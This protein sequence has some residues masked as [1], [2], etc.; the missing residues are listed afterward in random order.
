MNHKTKIEYITQVLEK[1]KQPF[2]RKY[3][4]DVLNNFYNELSIIEHLGLGIYGIDYLVEDTNTEWTDFYERTNLEC[5]DPKWYK[6]S[7]EGVYKSGLKV[8]KI[9]CTYHI[10]DNISNQNQP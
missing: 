6:G 4:D 7:L 8:L 9:S 2:I 10:P 1:N 5:T 3:E